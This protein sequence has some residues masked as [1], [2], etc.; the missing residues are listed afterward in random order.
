MEQSRSANEGLAF[1]ETGQVVG[2]LPVSVSPDDRRNVIA[3]FG[4]HYAN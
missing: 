2:H 3:K 4:T 1:N